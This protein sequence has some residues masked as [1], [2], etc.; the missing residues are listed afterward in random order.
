VTNLLD[1]YESLARQ[2]RATR[3]FLPDAVDPALVERLL[4]IAQW[5]PSGYN[6]QPTRFVVVEGRAHRSALRAACMDQP[7][8]DEAPVL[9]V[10]AGDHRA[11]EESFEES[12]ALDHAAGA[13]SPEYI[14]I[15]RKIVPLA[16]RNDPINLAWKTLLV[17]FVRWFRPIPKLPAA[18]KSEWLAKQAMLCAMNFMLAAEAAGLNTL[19]MEGFDTSRVRRALEL[20]CSWEPMLVISLGHAVPGSHPPKTRLPL[21]RVTLRR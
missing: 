14:A 7:Q 16:F 9:V 20:P 11:Y 21:E 19:P 1:A 10:F 6:L 2:R 8:I 17:P 4:G 12:L 3:H 18:G 5:A 15:L 13:T